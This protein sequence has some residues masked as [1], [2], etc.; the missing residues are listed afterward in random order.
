M[1]RIEEHNAS[2]RERAAAIPAAIRGTLSVD[3]FCEL[4]AEADIDG[5]IQAAERSLAAAAEQDT[6][7]NSPGFDLLEL[8]P[9]DTA[10]IEGILQLDL[11]GIEAA[12]EAGV[13]AHL[14]GLG[15]G[16]EAW[17]ADGMRRV[18]RA[19]E[20]DETCPF[21][22]QGLAESA[23]I[24]HYRV[25]FGEGYARLGRQTAQGLADLNQIHPPA[26]A[27]RLERALRVA[28]ERRQFWSRYCD[29]P[30]VNLDS[31]ALLRE[32]QA[33]RDGISAAL[34]AKRAAPLERVEIRPQVQTAIARF[35]GL[36]EGLVAL[37]EQLQAANDLIKT[38]KEQAAGNQMEAAVRLARL[39]AVKERFSAQVA[40]LCDEYMREKAAKGETEALRNRRGTTWNITEPKFSRHIRRPSTSISHISTRATGLTA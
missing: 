34:E 1:H 21:C 25:Y 23:I 12:A 8:P 16:G 18:A 37:N 26:L 24:S 29:V 6:I 13:R 22:E 14:A 7:R 28:N 31:D 2:L 30:E 35:H 15:P 17:V 4:P 5:K 33:S 36:R 38:A 32:W 9:F 20:N 27:A 19:G 11:P 10:G 40:P 3:E 39:R